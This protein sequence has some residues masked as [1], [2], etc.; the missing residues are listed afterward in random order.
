MPEQNAQNAAFVLAQGDGFAL[1]FHRAVG[2]VVQKSL[3]AEQR[4]SR[5][6]EIVGAPQKS[7]HLGQQHGEV[8]G[9][10]DEIVRA[11]AERHENVHIFRR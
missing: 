4:G 8:E 1:K 11:R 3:M 7:L 2:G 9:L 10:L 6:P 5:L